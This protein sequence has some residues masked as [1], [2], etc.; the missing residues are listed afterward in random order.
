MSLA[1][2][3]VVPLA[4]GKSF[5]IDLRLPTA[6]SGIRTKTQLRAAPAVADDSGCL[7]RVNLGAGSAEVGQVAVGDELVFTL[8]D[9]VSITL[10]LKKQMPSP[11]GGDVFLAEASG[12]EGV[13][14]AVVMRT[15]DGLTVDIQD[16]LNKKVY[17]ILST[18]TGVAVQELDW[19]AEPAPAFPLEEDIPA[20]QQTEEGTE[21]E[22]P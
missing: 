21:A 3:V 17:K 5:S 13:K 4:W 6:K 7:R 1:V 18:E 14:N 9:D 19:V 2:C 16:Y 20:E 22:R 10:A 12:Y 11:L 15:A 8:F